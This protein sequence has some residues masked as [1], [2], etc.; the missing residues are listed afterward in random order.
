MSMTKLDGAR[1]RWRAVYR[2]PWA[3][4][5][6]HDLR[7]HL[8]AAQGVLARLEAS[9]RDGYF[10]HLWQMRV[11]ELQAELNAPER[12]SG[13][14]RRGRKHSEKTVESTP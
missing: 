5:A 1:A 13:R 4:L 6:D 10:W 12:L 14:R 9:D 7:A 11:A 8:E 2:T 3:H